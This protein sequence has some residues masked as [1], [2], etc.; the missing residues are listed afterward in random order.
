MGD[1]NIQVHQSIDDKSFKTIQLLLNTCA[2]SDGVNPFSEHAILHMQHGQEREVQHYEIY[3]KETLVGYAHVD[4][5]DRV[6]GPSVEIAVL[7]DYRRHG[8]GKKLIEKIISD[9]PGQKIRLWAHG[10]NTGASALASSCGFAQV[11]T[12]WQ[13][14]RS[15]ISPIAKPE[16][17]SGLTI[18]RFDLDKHLNYWLLANKAAFANHPEQGGWTESSLKMR[19][20]EEWFENEGFQVVLQG[21]EIIGFVWT[22][23]DSTNRA[24]KLGEI[25]IVGVIPNWQNQ[26]LGKA[27]TLTALTHLRNQNLSSALLYVDESNQSAINLYEELGFSH[28]DTDTLFQLN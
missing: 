13:M 15:L 2:D 28:W 7:P 25:Y 10:L 22:K 5:S 27:L 1:L 17:P 20:N 23:I 6:Y 18:E 9:F 21:E 12:L 3:D 11:R 26:G 8:V 16:F 24:A 19:M 14:R 4:L